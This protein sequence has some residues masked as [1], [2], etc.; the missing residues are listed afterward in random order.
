[1]E[2]HILHDLFFLVDVSLGKGN[3]LLGLQI[4][5]TGIGVA[6]S[7]SLDIPSR[8]FNV[9]DVSDGTFLSG[10]V[11]MDGRVQLQL[12]CSFGCF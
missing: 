3:V 9:N 12:L 6:S 11:F 5:L 7:H 4:K 10:Q 8:G 1:M 2:G